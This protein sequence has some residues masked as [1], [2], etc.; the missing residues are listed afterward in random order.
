MLTHLTYSGHFTRT[1]KD[2]RINFS[3]QSNNWPYLNCNC[4]NEDGTIVDGFKTLDLLLGRCQPS[5]RYVCRSV[6]TSSGYNIS[7]MDGKLECDPLNGEH[8]EEFQ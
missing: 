1:C 4:K 5:S 7:Y 2:C 3:K 8:I 6:L